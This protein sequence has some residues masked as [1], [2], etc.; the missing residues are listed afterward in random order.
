MSLTKLQE[1][2]NP[3]KSRTPEWTPLTISQFRSGKVLAFDQSLRGC[4]VVAMSAKTGTYS[5]HHT[6]NVFAVKTFKTNE[7]EADGHEGTLQQYVA[8]EMKIAQWMTQQ[9]F[10]T[11]WQV[12]HETPPV[13]GG[14]MARPE[15]SLLAAAAVRT[16]TRGYCLRPM[17]GRQKH[18]KLICGNGNAKKTEHHAALKQSAIDLNI[19]GFEKVTNEGLRDACSIALAFLTGM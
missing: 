9:N 3:K 16:A 13:G 1:F 14:L 8:L 6:L 7:V 5:G 19:S 4:S 11:D 15:S 17:I 12:V 18:A 2:K 10:S